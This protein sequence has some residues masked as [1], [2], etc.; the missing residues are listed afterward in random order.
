LLF[1]RGRPDESGGPPLFELSLQVEGDIGH[2][3]P[4]SIPAT[5]TFSFDRMTALT[6]VKP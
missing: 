2:V 3:K 6:Y 5:L 1:G 4:L